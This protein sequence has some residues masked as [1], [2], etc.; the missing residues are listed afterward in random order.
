[1]EPCTFTEEGSLPALHL[2]VSNALRERK[3]DHDDRFAVAN[4]NKDLSPPIA[5]SD[6][7]DERRRR[8]D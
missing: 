4:V 2:F 7:Q 8:R 3:E 6:V 5:F 1:M